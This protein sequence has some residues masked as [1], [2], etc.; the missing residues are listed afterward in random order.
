MPIRWSDENKNYDNTNI[1]LYNSIIK[2][3]SEKNNIPFLGILDLTN[4][5]ELEDGLHP[6][7]KR[8][9]KIFVKVKDFLTENKWI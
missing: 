7:S 6:N 9:K 8:H 3:T 4:V 1:E 5:D 2:R